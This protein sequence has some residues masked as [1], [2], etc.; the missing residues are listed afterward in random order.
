[1]GNNTTASLPV[2]GEGLRVGLGKENKFPAFLIKEA[3]SHQL[4]AIR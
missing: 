2:D 1:M 3:F 4:S